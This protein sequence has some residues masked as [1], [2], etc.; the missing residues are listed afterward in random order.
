MAK[1]HIRLGFADFDPGFDYRKMYLYKWLCTQFDVEVTQ[2]HPD[3]L[4]CC[5]FGVGYMAYPGSVKILI[6]CEN[7]SADFNFY[8][9]AVTSDPIVFGDRHFRMPYWAIS[10]HCFDDKTAGRHYDV[11]MQSAPARKF[12]NFVYSNSSHLCAIPARDDIFHALSKYKHVDSG[13]GHLNNMGGKR[14]A[15]KLDF[16]HDY[17]FTIACENSIKPGYST[18][19]L[20]EPLVARSVPI[21]FGDPLVAQEFNPKAFVNVA[22]FK[23]LDDMVAYVKYLDENDEAYRAMLA[24]P[25]FPGGEDVIEKYRK[26]FEEFL[27][28]IFSREPS[29]ARRTVDYGWTRNHCA[30]LKYKC[31]PFRERLR[32]VI[33][34][35]RKRL[36]L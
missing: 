31:A 22:D 7:T 5:S 19:K 29:E 21:Y 9:Y 32:K 14:V 25:M 30:F 6:S 8:D 12:C 35:H 18:E 2:N 17:K 24:E 4:I 28:G 23:S 10:R 15:D 16:I 1:K 26:G 13:G 11:D 3:F 27:I 34:V 20:T 36:G 33:D